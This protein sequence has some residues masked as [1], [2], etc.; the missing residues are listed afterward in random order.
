M[1]VDASTP[2]SS[3]TG[4]GCILVIRGGA[5]GD[6]IVTLPVLAALRERF[7]RTRLEVLAYPRVAGLA[8]R[9]GW[10]DA[11]QAIE[12]RPLAGFFARK[13]VL[14][15]SQSERFARCDV[16]FSYLFD[17]DGIFQDNLSR[18]TSA[19][20]IPGPHRPSESAGV[21]APVQLLAPLERLAIFDA[22]PVPRL[23]WAGMGG[24][25]GRWIALHPGSGSPSKNW[26]L[27]RW[28]D[29][30]V[31]CLEGTDLG[32]MLVGG[33]AEAEAFACLERLIPPS[34]RRV[35][36]GES[37]ESVAEHLSRCRGFVG[38]DSGITHLAAAVGVPCLALWG[39]SNASVWRPL[40]RPDQPLHTLSHA[41]GLS[42]LPVEEVWAALAPLIPGA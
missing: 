5:V 40:I 9:A 32:L 38:H 8:V 24:D 10:A 18:V 19:Q 37:L 1:T 22:D 26:P 20:I 33:E 13:G 4:R 42:A 23:R 36:R 27:D 31:R 21:P 25:A 7:P 3:A 6:F 29:L 41:G 11:A 34:R 35:L 12:S 39:P 2:A 15:P 16:I 30:I 28:A 14:D 17:P